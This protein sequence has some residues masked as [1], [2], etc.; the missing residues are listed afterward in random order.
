MTDKH[1]GDYDD[2]CPDDQHEAFDRGAQLVS[3]IASWSDNK[4]WSIKAPSKVKREL[5][6]LRN[7]L[8]KLSA[9]ADSILWV[10][11]ANG[12]SYRP[13]SDLRG[14][15]ED[16]LNSLSDGRPKV[17]EVRKY[18]GTHAAALWCSHSGDIKANEFEDFLENL[19]E[20]AGFGVEGKVKIDKFA[21]AKEMRKEYADSDPPYWDPYKTPTH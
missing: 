3:D 1:I 4:R 18:L 21:L 17:N 8:S 2:L 16:V 6:Q 19:I 15:I 12:S 5:E 10:I 13:T 14:R 9:E 20:S 11:G 7:S